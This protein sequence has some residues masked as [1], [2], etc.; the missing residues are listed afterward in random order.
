MHTWL[1][2]REMN[3]LNQLSFIPQL[4]KSSMSC[5]NSQMNSF[6][7]LSGSAMRQLTYILNQ[8]IFL[9]VY[10]FSVGNRGQHWQSIFRYKLPNRITRKFTR[11]KIVIK[12]VNLNRQ[13][14]D[15]RLHQKYKLLHNSDSFGTVTFTLLVLS[16]FDCYNFTN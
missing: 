7:H 10:F 9:C 15:K 8:P 11:N 6:T 16:A 5:F 13:Q 14:E 1:M 3:D 12:Y 4:I 2:A